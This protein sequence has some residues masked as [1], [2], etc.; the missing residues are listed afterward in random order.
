MN[1]PRKHHY[2]PQTYLNHFSYDRGKTTHVFVLSKE[3]Y[4]IYPSSV[5]DT[6]A[7]R[8]FYTVN[9]LED[10]YVWEK[11][12][13]KEIEPILGRLLKDIEQRCGN[14]LIQ[15]DATILNSKE[16]CELALNII[17]QLL[18]GKR[19]REYEQNVY[20]KLL[21]QVTEQASTQFG[22]LS[23]ELEE[24]IQKFKEENK[25]F[26]EIAMGITWRT[27]SLEKYVSLIMQRH[28]IIY[29]IMGEPLLV[30]S[31]NPVVLIDIETCD[32]TPFKNGLANAK[33]L[34]YYPLTS[35]LLLGA[36]HPGLYGG[37]LEEKDCCL[38]ILDSVKEQRFI[39]LHNRKQKEQCCNYVYAQSRSV[40]E[41]L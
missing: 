6:A 8:D 17:C 18:R 7:E 11:Q 5:E 23:Q 3:P 28:F 30:T 20:N 1:E 10:K 38:Q 27:E 2:V 34:L 19:T 22:R 13:A 37:V 40:L 31:D 12:Y 39:N 29:K 16:K 14:V 41:N 33:T 9:T 26:K 21:P 25:F 4:K 15:E 36:Y 35:N 32:A 24:V